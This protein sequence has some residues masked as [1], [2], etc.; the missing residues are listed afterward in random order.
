VKGGYVDFDSACAFRGKRG[1]FRGELAKD[2]ISP[3]TVLIRLGRVIDG[4]VKRD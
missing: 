1:N 2:T 3:N 4:I